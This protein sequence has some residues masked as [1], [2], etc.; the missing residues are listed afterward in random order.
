[1]R[2]RETGAEGAISARE[3][4][5]DREPTSTAEQNGESESSVWVIETIISPFHCLYQDAL[6]FHTQGKLALARSESEASRLARAA[7]VLYV[8]A[9]E[10]LVHQAAVELGRPELAGL[11]ADPER[12]LPVF[13][14]WQVL[15]AAIAGSG[16]SAGGLHDLDSPPWPQFGELLSLRTDW[17]YPGSAEARR[18][19]YRS[20]LRGGEYEPMQPHQVPGALGIR[21]NQIAFPRTGLPRDPYALRPKHLDTARSV[22]D[23]A[24]EALDRRL[25]GAL[26][27]NQRH[28]C[29]PVR[30]VHT[31]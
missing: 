28:R 3:R 18:A 4:G 14:A 7:L 2:D 27:R 31:P 6:H 11:I 5:R 9:A 15:P 21:P 24:V 25:A 1:M 8:A 17:A 16:G 26:T 12:P 29:E 13:E 20:T 22:L 10:S 30:V 23:A 19:Y